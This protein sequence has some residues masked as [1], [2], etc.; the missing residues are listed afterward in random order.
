MIIHL[1]VN[2]VPYDD[3]KMTG[4][5]AQI[6]EDKYSVIGKFAEM[7]SKKIGQ[8]LEKD[9]AESLE[10]ALNG[11]QQGGSIFSDAMSDIET[12][13]RHALDSGFTGIQTKAAKQGVSHRF[14]HIESG[15][16]RVPFIDT[17]LYQAS[18]KAWID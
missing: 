6:L 9:L 13:F 11:I 7:F 14:K 3:G 2:D 15:I 4:E 10:N 5:V 12:D 18:F 17:G 16:K 1:G 8:H